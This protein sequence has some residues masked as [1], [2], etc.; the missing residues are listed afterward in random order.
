MGEAFD[1]V[2]EFFSGLF[3]DSG[4]KKAE[5]ASK[6]LDTVEKSL[7]GVKSISETL[8][9]VW[10]NIADG[11]S[12]AFQSIKDAANSTLN[13]LK[14]FWSS[15]TSIFSFKNASRV[16]DAA[17]LGILGGILYYLRKLVNDG[18][19]IGFGDLVNK[20]GESIDG[21]TGA[22]ESMQQ[23]I[24]ADALLSIA[25]AILVIAI[26]VGI[27][28]LID[29][30]RLGSSLTALVVGFT[31]LMATMSAM[32]GVGI[33]GKKFV[34]MAAGLTLLSGAILLLSISMLL[35]S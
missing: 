33:G 16:G 20:V 8:K 35:L 26:S 25:K 2:K 13:S 4:S 27:L 9:G 18:L 15:V 19:D 32:D 14:S 10:E 21:L 29:P 23:K 5:G 6:S 30:K 34:A 22:L 11:F 3:P 17:G 1:K 24:K 28:S 31:G 7:G 12:N